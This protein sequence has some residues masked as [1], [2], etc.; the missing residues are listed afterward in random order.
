MHFGRNLFF[1]LF[2]DE[3]FHN[4]MEWRLRFRALMRGL[5][6]SVEA[7]AVPLT[8]ILMTTS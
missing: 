5:L 1:S 3:A 8:L 6:L 4:V 7:V 2:D